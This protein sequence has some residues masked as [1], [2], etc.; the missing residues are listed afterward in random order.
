[1]AREGRAPPIGRQDAH[2]RPATDMPRAYNFR[3]PGVP[4]RCPQGAGYPL[5]AER[6]RGPTSRVP[7]VSDLMSCVSDP[8]PK[9]RSASTHRN[10]VSP[11]ATSRTHSPRG[12][13]PIHPGPARAATGSR[14]SRC[15]C[16]STASGSRDGSMRGTSEATCGS[17]SCGMR[18]RRPRTISAGSSRHTFGAADCSSAGWVDRPGLAVLAPIVTR[19]A[20]AGLCSL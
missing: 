15:R 9:V 18:R 7:G 17:A 5:D 10:G 6:A 20:A 14:T 12:T 4:S 16:S 19:V 8:Q 2:P 1:M 11:R 3:N 13:S